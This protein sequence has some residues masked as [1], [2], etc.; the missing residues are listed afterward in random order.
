VFAFYG[1][2]SPMTIN[3]FRADPCKSSSWLGAFSH[4]VIPHPVNTYDEYNI[5]TS[6]LT[7]YSGGS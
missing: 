3:W 2:A 6:R 5:L 1:Y 4:Q 7:G